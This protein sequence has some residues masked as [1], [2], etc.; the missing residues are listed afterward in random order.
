MSVVDCHAH[1]VPRPVVRALESGAFPAIGVDDHG[2]AGLRFHFPDL[3]VSPP[4]PASITETAAAMSWM[5]DHGVDRQVLSPWTDLL[6]YTLDEAA[7]RE[8]S[9]RMNEAL[10]ETAATSDR[11][12]ALGTIPLQWPELAAEELTRAHGLG[13]RGVMIG[14]GAPG[15]ELDDRRLDT[16]WGTAAE[17]G[18]PVVVHPIFLTADPRLRPYSLP[19]AIGRA[20]E[21]T[22]AIT[23][24]LYGGVLQRHPDL[25]L[26]VVHGG[27]ALPTLLP[28]LRRNH[29]LYAADAADPQ[30]GFERLYFDSVVFDPGVLRVLLGLTTPDR[31]VLGSD[32]PFPWEP[33]PRRV[34]EAA[35]LG[36]EATA[37]ILGH[38]AERLFGLTGGGDDGD[39]ADKVGVGR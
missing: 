31:V 13:C 39:H 14:T 6:G 15:V 7:A 20:N 23:R 25:V 33:D 16:V 3:A 30:D 29:A 17:L 18:L 24:L 10:V 27:A 28:R 34:V 2:G 37:A 11:L 32:Y 22:I 21:T 26:V 4:A 35:D 12:E 36:A 8:W 9:R 38:N 1:F 19:N 5:D